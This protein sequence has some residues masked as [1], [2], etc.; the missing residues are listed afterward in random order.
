MTSSPKVRLT[1]QISQNVDM[2]DSTG[3]LPV[4]GFMKTSIITQDQA[5]AIAGVL[6]GLQQQQCVKI[7]NP[8]TVRWLIA[9]MDTFDIDSIVSQFTLDEYAQ[10]PACVNPTL[11]ITLTK[12]S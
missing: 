7:G 11:E 9:C 5:Q 8:H 2:L 4:L 6:N 12:L 3:W 1:V 10:L